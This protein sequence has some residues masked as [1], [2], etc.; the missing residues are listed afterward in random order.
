MKNDFKRME[1]E[2][3]NLVASMDNITSFNEK[4][5]E[6]FK[7]R[8]EEINKLNGVDL[9]L[10]KLQFLFDL[11]TKLNKLINEESRYTPAIRYYTKARKAL[12]RYKYIQSFKGIDDE[13]KLIM[14]NLNC[15]LKEQFKASN[16][17]IDI[18]LESYD[19][20]IQ[21]DELPET[22]GDLYIQRC[23]CL[24]DNDLTSLEN[25]IKLSENPFDGQSG[26]DILEFIDASCSGFIQTLSESINIFNELFMSQRNTSNNVEFNELLT[27]KLNQMIIIY[28]EKYCNLIKRRF[29][30]EVVLKF[31]LFS[32]NKNKKLKI[33]F[34]FA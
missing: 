13:C 33:L 4:I 8:R 21:L 9:M 15:L 16:S 24:L 12:D 11:P 14:K 26:M 19:L 23:Y 17:T 27:R 34:Y 28:W 32:S 2:M 31:I 10:K 7:D 5:N 6:T 30:I 18:L 25:G 22:L 29:E 3:E 20:L 1:D